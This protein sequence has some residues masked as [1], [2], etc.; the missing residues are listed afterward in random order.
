MG[1]GTG[2][3]PDFDGIDHGSDYTVRWR[4]HLGDVAV[5]RVVVAHLSSRNFDT[6][7]TCNYAAISDKAQAEAANEGFPTRA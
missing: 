6:A 2:Y 4:R 3:H 1:E 7:I 5:P